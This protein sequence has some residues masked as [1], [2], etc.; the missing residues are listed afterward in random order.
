[1]P[2]IKLAAREALL[3]RRV[4]AH[5]RELGFTKD[6]HGILVPPSLSK[7]GYRDLHTPQREE[8]LQS[9]SAFLKEH[10]N[11]LIDHF[12]CG[13][14]IN[15]N[16]IQIRLE[17]IDSGTWQS[18][19]FRFAT[20]LWSIPVSYGFG[21][22]MRYL[23]WDDYSERLVGLFALGDPVFN[24]RARDRLVGWTSD[25]R[26]ERLVHVMDGYVVGA[27]PPFN[28]LLGGKLIA[29]LM[30]TQEVVNTFRERYGSS[31]G[32]ISGNA[33]N[34]HLVAITTTSALGKSSV[35][36][37]LKLN[38]VEYLSSIG[39]TDGYGHFHFPRELF[40]QMRAYLKAKRDPYANNH[41]YGDGP[42]WRLRTIRHALTL[43]DM[44]PDLLRHGLAR[45]VFFGHVADNAFE[46]LRGKRKRPK[47]D[48]L[49]S[50]SDVAAQC[51]ERWMKPRALRDPS[52][53]RITHADILKQIH[54]SMLVVPV[55]ALQH[56]G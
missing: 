9:E 38:G 21:R 10:G 55:S 23:V 46:I 29:S 48:S 42:N 11:T 14:A 25:D 28:R 54:T 26:V 17:L 33:K 45:E 7:E 49:L 3:R 43:L 8:R 30:R 53:S 50:A 1:M 12:A 34:A 31:E 56:R 37:R 27:V 44:N 40:E 51:I 5:L 20:L 47:Y 2:V 18:N 39:V 16:R 24:L 36:N 35:Y 41:Q 52:F 32:I 19:L 6:E 13:G 4:R 22:R 15:V